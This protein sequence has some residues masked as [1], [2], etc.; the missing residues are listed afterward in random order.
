M[1]VQTQIHPNLKC[2]Q[3]KRQMYLKCFTNSKKRSTDKCHTIRSYNSY[4]SKLVIN[5]LKLFMEIK[6]VLFK[7]GKRRNDGCSVW[8]PIVLGKTKS[9][10]TITVFAE[11]FS[12]SQYF[13][14]ME[15]VFH[16]DCS[17]APCACICVHGGGGGVGGTG[18]LWPEKQWSSR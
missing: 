5:K 1:L 15:S 8:M 2:L 18:S 6:G 17:S 3:L 4:I 13:M 11:T 7:H 10:S 14:I 16:S 9:L 12:C